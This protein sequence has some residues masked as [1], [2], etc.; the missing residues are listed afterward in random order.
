M[1]A[2]QL[3]QDDRHRITLFRG[4]GDGRRAVVGFEH[5]RDRMAG[6]APA[7]AP[8]HAERLGID[9]LVVQTARR[10][11][12]VPDRDAALAGALREATRNYAEVIVT[13][14]SMGGYAALLY[15]AACHADRIM[16]VSPQYCID[17]AV[18]P[19]DP[20]RHAKFA[21]I[22]RPMPRPE[23]LGNR[24]ARGA[25]IY[26]PAIRAD[27]AHAALIRA[28][29]PHLTP[30]ALPFGGHPATGVIGA[31]GGTGRIAEMVV[32]DRLD[33]ALVRQM[34]RAARP[35]AELYRL[36]L[37]AAALTRH[38]ARALRELRALAAGATPRIRLEAGLILLER[39]EELAVALLSELLD[40]VEAVPPALARRLDRA[41]KSGGI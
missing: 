17:P 1:R 21:R 23:T 29:F 19:F 22:G 39:G 20:D 3:H 4:A 15:S 9:A 11:W 30:I 7:A 2:E 36:N 18:A 26:D 27:R 12:F 8:R 10:D 35:R 37:A 33:A 6:F 41:L 32:Q 40:S 14:F 38:P 5:G 13:G 25:L 16:A 24:G 28:G 31:T 34:H